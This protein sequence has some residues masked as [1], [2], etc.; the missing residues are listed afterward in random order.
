MFLPFN[1]LGAERSET[2]GTGIGL[3]ITK[4]LVELMDGRIGFESEVGLGSTFWVEFPQ[5]KQAEQAESAAQAITTWQ[6][7]RQQREDENESGESHESR[8]SVKTV[9]YVEDNP[10]NLALMEEIVARIDNLAMVSAHNAEF[11]LELARSRNPDLIILDINL[12]GMNGFEALHLLHERPETALT[13]VIALSAAATK[14]DIEKGLKAGFRSYLT[15]PI[16][17]TEVIMTLKNILVLE[18]IQ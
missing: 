17:V 11:G 16:D 9:L 15:K 6:K 18:T 2:P 8:E 7:S 14:M 5:A 10:A 13:P 3:S 12:P 4:K 1:R